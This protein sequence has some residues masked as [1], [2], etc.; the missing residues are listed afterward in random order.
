MARRR[1]RSDSGQ[2]GLDSLLDTM[3]NV[4]GVL[5]VVLIVTQ[6]KVSSA[7]RRIRADLPEVTVEMEE[8]LRKKDVQVRARLEELKEPQAV[9]PEE[10]KKARLE[11][12]NIMVQRAK[13]NVAEKE[14]FRLEVDLETARKEVAELQ[15]Q[16][17]AEGGELAQIRSK[18]KESEKQL[19][20][21]KP[22]MVR[23]PNPRVPEDGSKEV[24]MIVRG[25]KLLYFDRAGILERLSAKV[26]PRKDL[27]S[28]NPKMKNRYDREKIRKFLD[29]LKESDPD[30]R[31]E[32][33]FHPNGTIILYCYPRDG[34]GDAVEDLENPDARGRRVMAQ[35]FGD[36]NYLRYFVTKD[37]FEHYV[38]MRR[39]AE[40][41]QIPV[42][43]I[44]AE[45][46]ARQTMN[47][48]ERK[49]IAEPDPD[50]KPPEPKLGP[51][52]PAPPPK[53]KPTVD[54]LD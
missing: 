17:V 6:V 41:I 10:L 49:I 7:A 2:G 20:S 11:L 52:P 42:G 26:A 34:R 16:M 32:F 30:F 40:K 31:F 18:L 22:K 27:K 35:A 4:V 46:T 36:R 28:S 53:K 50:W 33:N 15:L 38:A 5:I 12:Q 43:W 3:T 25:G 19:T 47:L 9:T 1:G 29:S 44:F 13:V 37:S 51:R 8:E 23:L 54:I 14:L 39:L 48:A 45:D 24:R 21:Q